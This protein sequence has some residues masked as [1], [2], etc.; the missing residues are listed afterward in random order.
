MNLWPGA[1]PILSQELSPHNSFTRARQAVKTRR[2]LTK[3]AN[4]ISE[5][6]QT[7]PCPAAFSVTVVVLV[8]NEWRRPGTQLLVRMVKD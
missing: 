7:T 3:W 8:E 5:G 4:V 2:L 6:A 1:V